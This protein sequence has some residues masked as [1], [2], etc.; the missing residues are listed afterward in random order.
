MK[1]KNLIALLL[2]MSMLAGMSV[3][4][5]A[6]DGLTVG[7]DKIKVVDFENGIETYEE[8]ATQTLQD[9][10]LPGRPA[11]SAFPA[12]GSID[13]KSYQHFKEAGL[14]N[15]DGSF[16]WEAYGELPTLD[17]EISAENDASAPE[18][19]E[20]KECKIRIVDAKG[21]PITNLCVENFTSDNANPAKD[22]S[23]EKWFAYTDL[24][25]VATLCTFPKTASDSF[26]VDQ[27][28]SFGMGKKYSFK[29][30]KKVNGA[31]Q[32]VW[33]GKTPFKEA[34]KKKGSVRI[35][36]VT[37]S[38]KAVPGLEINA[39]KY[40]ALKNWQEGWK[41]YEVYD[42]K[43]FTD[44]NGYFSSLDQVDGSQLKLCITQK[45]ENGKEIKRCYKISPSATRK[46]QYKIVW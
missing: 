45:A 42:L 44:K 34:S 46:N 39:V 31:Y 14:L 9:A 13:P 20:P 38:G 27:S 5:F 12:A 17:E 33:K 2:S 43:G 36:V 11:S 7:N 22:Y 23:K 37:K 40:S 1:V 24:N 19:I 3:S 30:C 4:S 29:N 41:E 16:N 21:N 15:E 28:H 10:D 6:D 18:I 35:K 25:G 26:Y 32:V 8:Y